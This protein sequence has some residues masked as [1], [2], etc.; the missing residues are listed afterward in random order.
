MSGFGRKGASILI[1]LTFLVNIVTVSTPLAVNG[2]LNRPIISTATVN[3]IFGRLDKNPTF[4][5]GYD[6]FRAIS[7]PT[8]SD[9]KFVEVGY[10]TSELRS[11]YEKL[12]GNCTMV[13][14]MP[15]PT[16]PDVHALQYLKQHGVKV[17]TQVNWWGFIDV[18]TTNPLDIYYN[19]GGFRAAVNQ[20]IDNHFRGLPLD[21]EIDPSLF[22]GV[23]V[24]DEVPWPAYHWAY[25][26]PPPDVMKYNQT[27]HQET[28]H[29]LKLFP[30]MNISESEVVHEWFNE[31]NTWVY[32][33]IYDY[34]KSKPEWKHLKVLQTMI[35][36]FGIPNCEVYEVKADGHSIGGG[37]DPRTVYRTVRQYKTMFPDLPCYVGIPP[38]W[39][40]PVS[41]EEAFQQVETSALAAYLAGADGIW[42]PAI[43]DSSDPIQQER[44]DIISAL[45]RKLMQ[46]PVLNPTPA[47]LV[48]G[49]EVRYDPGLFTE[50]DFVNHRFLAKGNLD[51]SKYDVIVLLVGYRIYE[52]VPPKLNDFV[53]SG[54]NLILT[55]TPLAYEGQILGAPGTR[56]PN[57]YGND[58]RYSRF[59]IERGAENHPL[60]FSDVWMVNL[61]SSN[62]LGL[63]PFSYDGPFSGLRIT[64][65][66]N[67][68]YYPVG[69]F[70]YGGGDF[71]GGDEGFPLVVYRNETEP[72]NGWTLFN[73]LGPQ[74]WDPPTLAALDS[75]HA[76]IGRAFCVNT[77]G[78]TESIS[79]VGQEWTLI[80]PA[81]L[82]GG[83]ILIGIVNNNSAGA[84]VPISF[85]VTKRFRLVDG[86]YEIFM[87]DQL[88]LTQL[89]PYD[90]IASH[91]G[92]LNFTTSLAG[93]EAKLFVVSPAFTQNQDLA[94]EIDQGD[95]D[96]NG[97]AWTYTY[98]VQVTNKAGS[99][100]SAAPTDY[101]LS[102]ADTSSMPN[103]WSFQF[104]PI[105]ISEI[106]VGGV[107]SSRLSIIIP[108]TEPPAS[109]GSFIVRVSCVQ[110]P[111]VWKQTDLITI[112][113]PAQ[114]KGC[115]IGLD[116]SWVSVDS[117]SDDLAQMQVVISIKNIGNYPEAMDTFD[118]SHEWTY[119]SGAPPSGSFSSSSL[120]LAS[121]EED[122]IF[123]TIPLSI[124]FQF[125]P[126]GEYRYQI[127]V[128]FR[129][130]PSISDTETGMLLLPPREASPPYK[131]DFVI[132]H[133]EATAHR[134]MLP[135]N[136]FG[137]T[138]LNLGGTRAIYRMEIEGLPSD[139]YWIGTQLEDNYE[140]TLEPGQLGSFYFLPDPSGGTQTQLN[141]GVYFFLARCYDLSHPG[142]AQSIPR[143]L[144]IPSDGGVWVEK[145]IPVQQA[146][147]GEAVN[148][149]VT[150]Y[151]NLAQDTTY[152]MTVGSLSTY[153]LNRYEFFDESEQLTSQLEVSIA[154]GG[155]HELV[156]HATA[157]DPVAGVF[158]FAISAIDAARTTNFT[159][160]CLLEIISPNF[161][162]VVATISPTSQT[163]KS[164]E[165]AS[166][167]ISLKNIGTETDTY[168][169]FLE[170]VPA[171]SYQLSQS[172]IELGPDETA[173]V[174][175]TLDSSSLPKDGGNHTFCVRVNSTRTLDTTT[176]ILEIT[177][178][179]VSVGVVVGTV[180]IIVGAIVVI[181]VVQRR[182]RHR[183]RQSKAA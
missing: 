118:I 178:P 107:G 103:S 4:N 28:G 180:S 111:T 7:N 72:H 131:F 80:S 182:R 11:G 93:W 2:K 121:G 120:N 12:V 119:L 68:T 39:Y 37:W 46:L 29:Y 151:S 50:F 141:P 128:S 74:T 1:L 169:L 130:D 102:L 31:K 143:H 174:E 32:S 88:D 149:T 75:I 158:P 27:Y 155:A 164:G 84:T 147:P 160:G 167:T 15:A 24:D 8:N 115:K 110:D 163:V 44:W 177:G 59:L 136:P 100:A 134:W 127:H 62:I 168:S 83:R 114:F 58:T 144:W 40:E 170:G 92:I 148:Y 14:I 55:G 91:N 150:V 18:S 21:V 125:D 104:D 137:A 142:V 10:T 162:E 106:P 69:T 17:I 67:H 183:H 133:N 90:T 97:T 159:L 61:S 126:P 98:E 99:P 123:W 47:V 108:K 30:Q 48:V 20:A 13:L 70:Q 86:S 157:L 176:A 22:W 38:P 172:V 95:V 116:P 6:A 135:G 33:W 101:C 34:F 132:V 71:L 77:A 23:Y 42:L 109:A 76:A 96:E 124:P 36:P 49:E 73:G 9:G 122:Q 66:E 87:A 79:T 139:F 145:Y 3:D 85:N 54:G 82:E 64:I 81:R 113:P 105:V 152:T 45:G 166:Y 25:P 56:S 16:V 26:F 19:F 35:P 51:L 181:V 78:I 146:K 156:I 117:L 89:S 60:D 173:D 129:E 138:I 179:T 65:N 161:Y 53:R 63:Q 41:E 5:E 154:A 94:I 57:R 153:D 165:S 112:A 52:E 171:N 43:F 140:V 175:L